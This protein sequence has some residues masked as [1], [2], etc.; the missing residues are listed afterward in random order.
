MAVN[1]PAFIISLSFYD[2]YLFIHLLFGLP[3]A[4]PDMDI[5]MVS[6][7]SQQQQQQQQAPP[8]QTA[9]WPDSMMPIEQTAFVNQNRYPNNSRLIP[10]SRSHLGLDDDHTFNSS[11]TPLGIV[12]QSR[13][14]LW[15]GRCTRPLRRTCCAASASAGAKAGVRWTRGPSCLSCTRH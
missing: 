13:C 1:Q 9:P 15:P 12:S 10:Q 6:H 8:N 4:Q 2:I 3:S 14:L 7:F 5:S 11:Q